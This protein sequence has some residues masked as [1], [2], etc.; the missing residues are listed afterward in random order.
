MKCQKCKKPAEELHSKSE[1]VD[2]RL[3]MDKRALQAKLHGKE[4]CTECWVSICD[5]YDLPKYLQNEEK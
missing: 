3:D 5:K 4:L 1:Y 2:M